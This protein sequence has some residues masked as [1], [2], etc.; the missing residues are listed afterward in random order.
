M[1][2]KREQCSTV[3][4]FHL[5]DHHQYANVIC[6]AVLVTL[7]LIEIHVYNIGDEELRCAGVSKGQGDL[8]V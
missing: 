8:S 4:V 2:L 5:Y 3:I 1:E 7:S 6:F